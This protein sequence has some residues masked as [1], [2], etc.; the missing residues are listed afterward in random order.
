MR[1]FDI[2][3]FWDFEDEIS[4]TYVV[5]THNLNGAIE[6]ELSIKKDMERT[7]LKLVGWT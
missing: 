1:F 2:L 3:V 7:G 5:F 4:H 6:I